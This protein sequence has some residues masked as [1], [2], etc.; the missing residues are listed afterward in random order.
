VYVVGR[1]DRELLVP[2]VSEVV[3]SI[4]LEAGRMVVDIPEE[5]VVDP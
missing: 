1:G 5:E 4:D 3:V 2:A